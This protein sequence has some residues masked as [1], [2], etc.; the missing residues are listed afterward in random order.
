MLWAMFEM[1]IKCPRCDSPIH[2]DGPFRKLRCGSCQSD[3]DFPEDVWNDLLEDVS[4]E[5]AGFKPGEGSSSNIFGHFNMTFLYGALA[6]YCRECK[7]DFDME[8]EY[9]PGQTELTCSD[10]GSRIPVFQAPN[11]FASAV[12]GA[13]LV[14]GAWPEGGDKQGKSKVSSPVAYSCPQCGG[15]LMI[16]GTERLVTCEYCG[17]RVYLPDDLW[18]SLHPAKKKNRWFVGFDKKTAM[19]S[20][21]DD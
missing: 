8:K 6:P 12:P 10:C 4:G 15:S 20:I 11:W 2:V 7:R 17:T 18:L 9:T 14:A 16:D 13:R 3:I 19:E 21:E 5:I 1:S